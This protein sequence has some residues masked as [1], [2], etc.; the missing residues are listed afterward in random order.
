M[1]DWCREC[2]ELRPWWLLYNTISCPYWPLS[3]RSLRWSPQGR[4]VVVGSLRYC[5]VSRSPSYANKCQIISESTELKKI[6]KINKS[7][8]S[9]LFLIKKIFTL[10]VLKSCCYFFFL[11]RFRWIN[12][13]IPFFLLFIFVFDCF[14]S[15]ITSLRVDF[16]ILGLAPLTLGSLLYA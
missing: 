5:E 3:A 15:S 11:L 6:K 2:E 13:F 14:R 7:N 12:V 1:G 9:E 4:S 8:D 10:N 16:I